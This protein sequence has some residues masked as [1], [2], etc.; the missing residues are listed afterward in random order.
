MRAQHVGFGRTSRV[1]VHLRSRVSNCLVAT[2]WQVDKG[3]RARRALAQESPRT[4]LRSLKRQ[5]HTT[6][7]A[8][9]SAQAHGDQSLTHSLTSL[10]F[11]SGNVEEISNRTCYARGRSAGT[12][13]HVHLAPSIGSGCGLPSKHHGRVPAL[14][15]DTE[16]AA[17]SR[18]AS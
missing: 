12:C 5:E 15:H 2:V 7:T 6:D 4:A 1:S 14:E 3:V 9:R 17:P 16:P 13:F 10:T 18:K 11:N 8:A